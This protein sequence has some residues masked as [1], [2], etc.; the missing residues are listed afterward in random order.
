MDTRFSSHLTRLLNEGNLSTLSK[1]LQRGGVKRLPRKEKVQVASIARRAGFHEIALQILYPLIWPSTVQTEEATTE[2]KAVYAGALVKIGAIE[3]AVF[4][5]EQLTPGEYPDV[6]L[7]LAHA[8]M[9]QWKYQNAIPYLNQYLTIQKLSVYQRAVGLLN[10]AAC[11]V[12]EQFYAEAETALNELTTNAGA[13]TPPHLLGSAYEISAQRYMGLKQWSLALTELERGEKF[14]ANS[15]TVEAFFIQKWRL[16]CEAQRDGKFVDYIPRWTELRQVAEKLGHWESLRDLD[17]IRATLT[18]DKEML[19][20]LYFGTPFESFR[21]RIF[22]AST[23]SL[24]IPNEYWWKMGSG[25]EI[26]HRVDFFSQNSSLALVPGSIPQRLLATLCSDFYRPFRIG[27]LYSLLYP[28]EYFNP[29]TSPARA[30]GAIRLLRKHFMH[31]GVPINIAKGDGYRLVGEGCCLRIPHRKEMALD[32]FRPLREK[33][34]GQAFTA[35]QA[36]ACI[37]ISAAVVKK[38]LRTAVDEGR[39]LRSGAGPSTQYSFKEESFAKKRETL[40]RRA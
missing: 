12:V 8:Q 39:L 5:L 6:L 36:Q 32:P 10:L 1:E 11:F 4:I 15:P 27:M 29:E 37:G 14:L 20:R 33:L 40:K 22:Q 3:E 16:S 13:Q 25:E 19:F 26:K 21:K 2:E 23:E 35:S 30:Y 34:S 17:F 18:R 31:Q 24:E 7:F 9:F 28:G 38:F